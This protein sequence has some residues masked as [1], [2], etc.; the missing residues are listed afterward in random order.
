MYSWSRVAQQSL[1]GGDPFSSPRQWQPHRVSRPPGRSA[2]GERRPYPAEAADLDRL[3]A[4]LGRPMRSPLRWEPCV[5]GRGCSA[6]PAGGP[7]RL[8]SRP[9]CAPPL[10]VL[11][12]RVVRAG[13]ATAAEAPMA[14]DSGGAEQSTTD[15]GGAPPTRYRTGEQAGTSRV[16]TTAPLVGPS[17]VGLM[18]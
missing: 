5:F 11:N 6:T 1:C 17:Q 3:R 8:P 16:T 9:A 7:L 4:E 15:R 12:G 2:P 13:D 18:I 10:A 14:G